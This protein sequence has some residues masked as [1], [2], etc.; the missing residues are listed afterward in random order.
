MKESSAQLVTEEILTNFLPFTGSAHLRFFEDNDTLC[1]EIEQ[2]NFVGPLIEGRE[3]ADELS[4]SI[5]KG[6]TSK[7]LEAPIGQDWLTRIHFSRQ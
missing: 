3:G 2:K 4:L 1:L 5:I 7:I 6:L